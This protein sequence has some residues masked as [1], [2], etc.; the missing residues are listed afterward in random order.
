MAGCSELRFGIDTGLLVLLNEHKGKYNLET[1]HGKP[2]NQSFST[3][4]VERNYNPCFNSN[5]KPILLLLTEVDLH[6]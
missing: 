5:S 4:A 3:S 6:R 2:F 1:K